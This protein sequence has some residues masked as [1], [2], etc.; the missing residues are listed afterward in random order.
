[1]LEEGHVDSTISN[2]MD[3]RVDVVEGMRVI[4]SRH[5]CRR[6][7]RKY[8]LQ[9]QYLDTTRSHGAVSYGTDHRMKRNADIHGCIDS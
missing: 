2:K 8:T 7:K 5:C 9:Y 1:M 4:L 6:V 3:I